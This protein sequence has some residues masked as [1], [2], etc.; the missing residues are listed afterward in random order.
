M[1]IQCTK[2]LRDEKRFTIE[3]PKEEHPLY[4]WHANLIMIR[5]KKTLVLINDKTRYIIVLYGVK[6]KELKQLDQLVPEAI[7][8]TLQAEGIKDEVVEKYVEQMNE[9]TYSKTKDRKC[10]ARLNKACENVSFFE[11]YIN[12]DAIIQKRLSKKISDIIVGD[13]KN[14]Y[15]NPNEEMYK[16]LEEMTKQ[17]VFP[18][19]AY[20]LKV[21]LKLEHH[22]VWRR[23]SVPINTTFGGLHEVL[24]NAFGWQD[25]HLHDFEIYPHKGERPAQGD[26]D[27]P[28]LRLVPDEE[29]FNYSGEIPMKME[30]AVKL[31]E[32]LPTKVIYNYDF[33]DGWEHEIEVEEV[34]DDN[35]VNYAVCLDG[36]G[37]TPPEDV[38]GEGGYEEFLRVIGDSRNEGYDEMLNWAEEQGY[39]EFDLDE[40]NWRLKM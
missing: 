25:S 6:A 37:N 7:K 34:T 40:I 11:D 1:L 20:R 27:N 33:G 24:Q 10:V 30:N 14:S 18:S 15:L 35:K 12:P 36:E 31:S 23:L 9:F 26:Q 29:L 5:Q 16:E 3:E 17:P 38:G 28:A 13:G 32:C 4:M 21:T 22:A 19:E 39:E 2:K 8:Q